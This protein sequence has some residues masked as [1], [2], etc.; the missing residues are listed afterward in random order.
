MFT[1]PLILLMAAG[2]MSTAVHNAQTITKAD[3]TKFIY[4][5]TKMTWEHG[6]VYC[7]KLGAELAQLSTAEDTLLASSS[8]DWPSWV[9][10]RETGIGTDKYSYMNGTLVTLDNWGYRATY[11]NNEPKCVFINKNNKKW[12]NHWECKS[13]LTVL[14][15]M[16][17]HKN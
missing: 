14:C 9:G 10:M 2:S 16:Q 13:K 3:G 8:I 5:G 11:V 17:N 6:K 4:K 1:A 15:Q 12:Y 7:W